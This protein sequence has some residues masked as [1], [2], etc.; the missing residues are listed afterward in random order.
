MS[1]LIL[2]ISLLIMICSA[3]VFSQCHIDDWTALKALYESTNGDNWEE[4]EGWEQIT[5]DIP[6][7]DCD[8]NKMHGVR[9]NKDYAERVEDLFLPSN[10]LEGVIP[11]KICRLH[12]LEEFSLLY[13]KIGEN[14]PNCI[15][16]LKE[17]RYIGLSFNLL[18]GKIPSE[19]GELSNL[20]QLSL[21]G[22]QLSGEIPPELGNLKKLSRLELGGNQFTGEI[23]VELATMGYR[24]V[25][26]LNANQLSG[27]IPPEFG[28][29]FF[30]WTTLFLND[31]NL[32]GCYDANLLKMC[33][34]F[35]GI[36]GFADPFS[37][38]NLESTFEEF[39]FEAKGICD[40]VI[41]CGPKGLA[42][43]VGSFNCD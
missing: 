5:G 9:L 12:N 10:N 17:L 19:I 36:Y 28:D 16:E 2:W 24:Y 21:I 4:K 42:P 3:S 22:N 35:D 6:A 13:N 23:P 29:A 31:N 15:A 34:A 20:T 37:L 18:T 32:S 27:C 30:D 40:T 26:L 39:C 43:L 41:G 33:D 11:P 25:L 8:L 1:Q 38:N 7:I 14:I